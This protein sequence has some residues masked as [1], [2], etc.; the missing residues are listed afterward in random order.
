MKV[1]VDDKIPYI[2]G[3]IERLA[4]EVA[5][6][7]GSAISKSDV[8]D[9]DVLIVRTRTRCDQA[10]LEGTS[11]R[12]IVTATIGYDHI[13]TAYCEAHGIQW[14]NCPGCNANSVCQYVHHALEATGFLKPSY[15]IGVVGVG[16][17]G[18]LVAADLEACGMKVLRCD[19]PKE[20]E[21][22]NF[23]CQCSMVNGKWLDGKYL[24]LPT[25]QAEADIITFHTPLTKEGP[26]ATYHMADEQFFRH[27]LHRPLIINASR[28]GVVD[29]EA[30]LWALN[31]GLIADAVI[32][33]WEGEPDLNREL[34]EQVVIGTPHV[35]GYSADGK[36]NATRMSLEAVAQFMGV[37]FKPQIDLPDAPCL[38]VETLLDDSRQLKLHP[39]R[40]EEMRGNYPVRRERLCK[41]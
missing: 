12:L 24:D 38:S 39:D 33:T 40:F 32:D 11:V 27:L 9:A 5:Y 37:D 4:N 29:N 14:T 34:L 25:I 15:T 26:W 7:P 35:A 21:Q 20:A 23:N 1:I 30:L 41:V 28:G 16:H 10:L 8:Q 13:D 31:E 6:L 22:K 2:R 19:P 17:V 36:A 18:S 3:Q